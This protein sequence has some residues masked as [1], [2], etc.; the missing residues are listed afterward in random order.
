LLAVR[1][2]LRNAALFDRPNRL[3]AIAVEHE[4]E[5]LL[6]RLDHHVAHALAGVDPRQRRL[7]RQIVIPD[8]VMH[9]LERPDQLA[10]FGSQRHHGIR[11]LVVAGPLAAPEIGARR[12]RRQK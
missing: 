6:G 8:I 9:G 3:A 12:R 4:H 11:M 5:P 10:G 7:R 1:G 2:P